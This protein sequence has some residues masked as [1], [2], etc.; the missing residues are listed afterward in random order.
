MRGTNG[1]TPDINAEQSMNGLNQLGKV[2]VLR[3]ESAK[4]LEAAQPESEEDDYRTEG[5]REENSVQ[6]ARNGSEY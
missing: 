5:P 4:S 6:Q 3:K 1:E 2:G